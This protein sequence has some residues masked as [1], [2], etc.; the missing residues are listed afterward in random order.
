MPYKIR[1][2]KN[3]YLVVNTDTGDV[4]GTHS[5]REKATSQMR[6]LYGIEG[7]MIPYSKRKTK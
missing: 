4:R 1:K 5:T 7:G 3:K 6:L 2:K